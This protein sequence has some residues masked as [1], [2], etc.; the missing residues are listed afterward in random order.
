MYDEIACKTANTGKISS[1]G[2]KFACS[3]YANRY[4]KLKKVLQIH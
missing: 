4:K 1:L 3:K 2:Q